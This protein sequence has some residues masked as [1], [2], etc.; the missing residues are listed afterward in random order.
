M[1]WG[2]MKFRERAAKVLMIITIVALALC[3]ALQIFMCYRASSNT[4]FVPCGSCAN[5]GGT[6][7]AGG[8]KSRTCVSCCQD[9]TWRAEYMYY[10]L[11]IF[12]M[13]FILF[14]IVS[15][16]RTRIMLEY[17]TAFGYYIPRGFWYIFLGFMTIQ[18]GVDDRD[19]TI[20]ADFFG[21]CMIGVALAQI[22]M[23][24]LCYH[25]YSESGR[26][27]ELNELGTWKSSRSPAGAP[28]GG[29]YAQPGSPMPPGTY[30]A[31][32]PAGVYG[33]PPAQGSSASA[34]APQYSSPA[35]SAGYGQPA[36]YGQPSSYGQPATYGQPPPSKP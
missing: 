17:F 11:R 16:F 9:C 6:A 13:I 22:F 21:F 36:T 33:A 4:W 15:E 24:L 8:S 23:G 3:F 31:P 32:P 14:S 1:G 26:D 10:V 29:A 35:G 2:E 34:P 27:K 30:G 18:S 19:N 25:E 28:P 20:F 5:K 12:T 7:P